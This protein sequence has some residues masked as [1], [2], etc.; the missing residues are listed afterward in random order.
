MCIRQQ[1]Q[2]RSATSAG[3][4]RV[5]AERG[6]VVDVRRAG[7]DRVAGDLELH[8]VDA[9]LRA[10]AA[11]GASITG[12]TRAQLLVGGTGSAHGAGRLA[13]DV[14]DARALGG[15]PRGHGRSPRR[16]SNHSP[17]SENES[18]VTLTMPM[19]RK[20]GATPAS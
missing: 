20:G 5:V 3:E 11:R 4:R 19:M 16:A 2:P 8:R 6:D 1:S 18:G 14:E 13:A 15:E 9:E 7:G 17:P 12:T 10:G